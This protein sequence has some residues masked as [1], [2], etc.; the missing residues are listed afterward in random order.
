MAR[1]GSARLG[2]A[3]LGSARLGSIRLDS[4]PLVQNEECR[5][6]VPSH[7]EIWSATGTAGRAPIVAKIE[8]R[9]GKI[10]LPEHIWIYPRSDSELEGENDQKWPH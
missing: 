1:L 2:L 9:T 5:A 6:A 4:A 8:S 7:F 3:R 10:P